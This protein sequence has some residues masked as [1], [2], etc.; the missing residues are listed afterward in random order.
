MCIPEEPQ[1]LF[2]PLWVIELYI[3]LCHRHHDCN[4]VL[5]V[6]VDGNRKIVQQ[7]D[8]H[9]SCP[10]LNCLIGIVICHKLDVA[11]QQ[12]QQQLGYDVNVGGGESGR[13]NK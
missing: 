11:K 9:S 1:D 6:D 5:V 13:W 10:P 8:V 3:V 2:A 7:E 12:Q 4:P